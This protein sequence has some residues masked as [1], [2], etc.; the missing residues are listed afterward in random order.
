MNAQ[1]TRPDRGPLRLRARDAEDLQ[2]LAVQLQDALVPLADTAYLKAEKRFVLVA[3]RFRWEGAPEEVPEE[4]SEAVPEEIPEPAGD[5]RFEDAE[6]DPGTFYQR[7]NCGL[8]FDKV[9]G[10][11]VRGVDLK[12]RRQILSLLTI[13]SGPGAVTL[14]FSGGAE[15]RLEVERILCHLEDLGEPWPT[16][17]RPGHDLDEP[18]A[19]GS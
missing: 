12:D 2:A 3:N 7:V 14:V 6:V 10:V 9:R 11:K 16:R 17:W 13:T 8:C 18:E 5:A 4:I 1:A 19:H 15:I